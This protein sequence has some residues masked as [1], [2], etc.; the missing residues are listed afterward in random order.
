MDNL[1]KREIQKLI[2][3]RIRARRLTLTMTQSELGGAELSK[4][5]VSQIEKGRIMPSVWSLILMAK[6]LGCTV[7]YLIGEHD[8]AP[9]LDLAD[10]ARRAGVDPGAAPHFLEL[11]LKEA[12]RRSDVNK[13]ATDERPCTRSRGNVYGYCPDNRG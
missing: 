4:A 5:H 13:G 11:V 12:K 10:I 1:D 9:P 3:S 8:E 6:R 2:G 7:S